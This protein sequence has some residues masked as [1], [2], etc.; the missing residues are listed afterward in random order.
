MR[1][2]DPEQCV[3]AFAMQ[4]ERV[5][6][7]RR[8]S[9]R[10]IGFWPSLYETRRYHVS[11]SVSL[12][13]ESFPLPQKCWA[14]TYSNTTHET[15]VYPESD[16]LLLYCTYIHSNQRSQWSG[17]SNLF[18]VFFSSLLHSLTKNQSKGSSLFPCDVV[19]RVLCRQRKIGYVNES[20]RRRGEGK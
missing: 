17:S 9:Q 14:A 6:L 15:T 1:R 20:H 8:F 2:R 11:A 16:I 13:R 19:K 3:Q 12:Y 10:L 18:C 4:N 7:D 5:S